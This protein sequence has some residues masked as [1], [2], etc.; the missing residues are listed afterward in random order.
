MKSWPEN[1]LTTGVQPVDPVRKDP[2]PRDHLLLEKSKKVVAAWN[3]NQR[4][5]SVA[6]W[7]VLHYA[8]AELSDYLERVK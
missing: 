6:A 1:P 8:M 5:G 7:N 2:T 3:D 4:I